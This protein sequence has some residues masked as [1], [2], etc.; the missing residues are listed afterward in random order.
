VDLVDHRGVGLARCAPGQRSPVEGRVDSAPTIAGGLVLCGTRDGWV[1][2]LNRDDGRLVWRF[3]AAPRRELMVADGQ[4]ESPWPVL[5]SVNATDEGVWAVA[6]RHTDTDG[7]MWWWRLDTATG[8][9]LAD[10]RVGSDQR[11]D[12]TYDTNGP[13]A[14]G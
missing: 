11:K 9:S 3:L 8:K 1:Y 4:L 7:G 5:G 12:R 14:G 2:A 13:G 6:G 10:G